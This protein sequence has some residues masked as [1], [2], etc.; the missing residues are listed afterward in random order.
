MVAPIALPLPQLL[1]WLAQSADREVV[2]LAGVVPAVT[3]GA[4]ELV[5]LHEQVRAAVERRDRD[6]DEAVVL[7][8]TRR[9]TDR[10][11]DVLTLKSRSLTNR[12]IADR[13]GI[14]SSTVRKLIARARG[15]KSLSS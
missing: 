4:S 2:A 10:Q 3:D 15:R 11:R 6:A 13:L 9:L 12:D 14:A 5:A 8:T 7:L 1:Q